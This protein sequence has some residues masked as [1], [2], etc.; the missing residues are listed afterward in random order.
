MKSADDDWR[1][2]V[3]RAYRRHPLQ[4]AL[5]A[6]LA[7]FSASVDS[8]SAFNSD[9]AIGLVF[10]Q[11][12]QVP[13][14]DRTSRGEDLAAD[15][16]SFVSALT[17]KWSDTNAGTLDGLDAFYAA[18]VDYFG[19]R[20]SRERVLADKRRFVE[21]WPERT[22]KIRSSY[23]QCSASECLVEGSVEWE[24]RSAARKARASGVADFRYVLM[25]LGRTFVIRAEGG[26]IIQRRSQK[27]YQSGPAIAKSASH[28]S[29]DGDDV[30]H[31]QQLHPK[32]ESE[33]LAEVPIDE[34]V[35]RVLV[36]SHQGSPPSRPESALA[37]ETYPDWNARSGF[38]DALFITAAVI[39]LGFMLWR[40][41]RWEFRKRKSKR[42]AEART[43]RRTDQRGERRKHT[44]GKRSPTFPCRS[45]RGRWD[46]Y[47]PAGPRVTSKVQRRGAEK[48]EGAER[49]WQELRE[50]V[51]GGE[52]EH[53]G[54]GQRKQATNW[55]SDGTAW[56]I[57]LEVSP[58]AGKDEIVRSYRRKIQRC[59]PDRVSGLA[60]EFVLLAEKRTKTLNEAYAQALRARKQALDSACGHA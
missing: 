2:R 32:A 40:A 13:R 7:L 47:G 8:A 57:V 38:F 9:P 52:A 21:R 51:K 15:A 20:L 4:I 16:K 50:A 12:P 11:G 31:D 10:A 6:W 36:V 24:T 19:K 34:D 22:Y 58:A 14:H 46:Q 5:G 3:G 18:Q 54:R 1:R 30:T 55:Q 41:V 35:K 23:E 56:W 26:N 53:Q 42:N 45:T 29:I 59:H 17:S 25:P 33:T 27:P 49:R 43:K 39:I 60:P 37:R 44:N 28:D 48:Q